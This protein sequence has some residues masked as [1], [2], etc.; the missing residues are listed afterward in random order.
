MIDELDSIK[1]VVSNIYDKLSEEKK[2]ISMNFIMTK[3]N[4]R[5]PINPSIVLRSSERSSVPR[6]GEF[7]LG[8]HNL[9][10]YNSVY[11]ITEK[12]NKFNIADEKTELEKCKEG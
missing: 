3:S 9:S 11:I 6:E 8:L 1:D 5:F 7:F 10:V 2:Q 12:N 4:E